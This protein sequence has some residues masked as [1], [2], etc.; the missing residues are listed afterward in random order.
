MKVHIWPRGNN[1]V[2]TGYW[3]APTADCQFKTCFLFFF[4]LEMQG[5]GWN[6]SCG[7]LYRVIITWSCWKMWL[8]THCCN[9][10][11]IVCLLW[12]LL[13]VS[14]KPRALSTAANKPPDSP[15]S[16]FLLFSL[17]RLT[18][19]QHT[20]THLYIN[21]YAAYTYARTLRSYWLT[22]PKNPNKH[23]L[24]LKTTASLYLS[25]LLRNG[26]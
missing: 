2:A 7:F 12:Q 19:T 17:H 21:T 6:A 10:F 23:P 20:H 14:D 8:S 25:A 16:L 22:W 26:P 3:Y 5:L 24:P 18:Q 13:T 4:L 9:F 15:S 1:N 11:D